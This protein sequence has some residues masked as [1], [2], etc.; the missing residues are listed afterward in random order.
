[1]TS[2][3]S[4]NQIGRKLAKLA[5]LEIFGWLAGWQIRIQSTKSLQVTIQK[6]N[7]IAQSVLKLSH[8]EKWQRRPRRQRQCQQR[9]HPS[10]LNYSPRR[11][12]FRRGQKKR[13][14]NN[15]KSTS[16]NIN[17]PGYNDAERCQRTDEQSFWAGLLSSPKKTPMVMNNFIFL[18]I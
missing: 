11:K 1:M 16:H 14:N 10:C 17:P 4:L 9:R 8:R 5:H 18:L 6:I 7:L 13:K 2:V 3:P 15:K 12:V